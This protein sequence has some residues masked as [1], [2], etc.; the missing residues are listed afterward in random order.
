MVVFGK[1][2]MPEF[3]LATHIRDQGLVFNLLSEIIAS[4]YQTGVESSEGGI[5]HPSFAILYRCRITFLGKVES[6]AWKMKATSLCFW[7]HTLPAVFP[8]LLCENSNSSLVEASYQVP[9]LTSS[10]E[11]YFQSLMILICLVPLKVT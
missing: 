1:L 10:P 2:N 11:L 9:D 7:P 6:M 3:L 5:C 4:R 8:A